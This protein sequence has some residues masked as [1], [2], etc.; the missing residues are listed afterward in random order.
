MA[1]TA[2]QKEELA[3]L[4]ASGAN[5]REACVQCEIKERSG[6]RFV[7]DPAFRALIAKIRSEMTSEATGRL[8]LL[9]KSSANV[10]GKL[11]VDETPQT[12]M[13]AAEIILDKL[14]RFREIME[15]EGRLA[16]LE[17][18]LEE[19]GSIVASRASKAGLAGNGHPVNRLPAD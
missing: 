6:M 1:Y 19:N 9:A 4:I 12:R 2:V 3:R 15:L 5:V 13:K 16:E 14:L 10:L 18:R 17:R 8:T 11:L 7:G